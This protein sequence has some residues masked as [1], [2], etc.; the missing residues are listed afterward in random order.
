MTKPSKT[1]YKTFT[2][3]N[4]TGTL[5]KNNLSMTFPLTLV[6]IEFVI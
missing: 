4:F 5:S 3:T 6:L 2:S 1:D